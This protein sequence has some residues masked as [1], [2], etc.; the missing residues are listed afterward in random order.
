MIIDCHALKLHCKGSSMSKKR[1]ISSRILLLVLC[2]QINV[3][4][5]G[6]DE[7]SALTAVPSFLYKM[8]VR[9]AIIDVVQDNIRTLGSPRTGIGSKIVS[10]IN[11]VCLSDT[12]RVGLVRLFGLTRQ[13]FQNH[14]DFP[15]T[16]L[17][18]YKDKDLID[19]ALIMGLDTNRVLVAESVNPN[20]LASAKTWSHD[21]LIYCPKK[22]ADS[23]A[24]TQLSK[25]FVIGHEFAH[26]YN[27]D[28]F[29]RTW[30]SLCLPAISHI[31]LT[32]ANKIS[33]TGLDYL[34]ET[35]QIN[36]N[37]F[38]MMCRVF[39]QS[40][41]IRWVLNKQITLI[42][43]RTHE[44]RADIQAAKKLKCAQ[45]GVDFLQEYLDKQNK[46]PPFV[47]VISESMDNHP[48]IADRIA[49]LKAIARK[50]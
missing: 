47:K 14:L 43:E 10:T 28:S 48:P 31:V 1:Q 17:N 41:S 13:I 29:S 3:G 30:F 22:F 36:L 9:E 12:L 40:F 45:G 49:Y 44:K 20:R 7:T 23:S 34:A 35:S 25:R 39:T 8:Y 50:Q 26:L 33:Q 37:F 15:M 21:I 19:I 27:K 5:C 4:L 11:I 46:L 6:K 38:K 32:T 18:F 16:P 42:Y 24:K 2:L